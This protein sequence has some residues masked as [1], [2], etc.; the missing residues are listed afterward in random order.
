MIVQNRFLVPSGFSGITAWPFI[1]VT[2]ASDKALI[3]HEMV[4]YRE[5]AWITPIWWLRYG[6]SKSF[7]V[8]AEARAYKAQIAAGGMTSARAATWLMK[9]NSKLSYGQAFLLLTS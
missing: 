9:Y 2:D 4:H 8:A 1:F 7:R 6:L 3:V 5:M